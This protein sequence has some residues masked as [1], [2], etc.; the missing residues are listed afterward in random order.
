MGIFFPLLKIQ[1]SDYHLREENTLLLEQSPISA[2]QAIA[3]MVYIRQRDLPKLHEYKYQGVDHS[4]ISKHI[5]KPFYNNV[6]I[7]FFPMSMA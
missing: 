3:N 6:A 7:K 2:S 5:L 1:S 4:P